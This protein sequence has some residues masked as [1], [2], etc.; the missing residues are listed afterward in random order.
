MV[1]G[2]I[3][4]RNKEGR[5]TCQRQLRHRTGTAT[6]DNHIGRSIGIVHTVDKCTLPDVGRRVHFEK[7]LHL[8]L[9]DAARLPNNLHGSLTSE[10]HNPRTHHIV[11]C[12]R[13]ERTSD[14]KHNRQRGI[15]AIVGQRLVTQR[16][17][18]TEH[19][20][21]RITRLDYLVGLEEA[22][23]TVVCNADALRLAAHNLIDQTC[24]GVL[25]LNNGRNAHTL[26]NPQYRRTCIATKANH[27]IGLKLL[28]DATRTTQA[29]EQEYRQREIFERHTTLKAHNRQTLDFVAGLWHC[30]HLHLADRADKEYLDIVAKSRSECIGNSNRRIYV[31]TGTSTGENY[32]FHKN[33]PFVQCCVLNCSFTQNSALCTQHSLNR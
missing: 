26:C 16:S 7:G 21:K 17:L 4:R 31:T 6:R 13:T 9:V 27:N 10:G 19:R 1:L 20:T 11:E 22:L 2:N 8:G 24:I 12:A 25:L 29:A 30:R 14:N 23:H 18:G 5:L 28:D 3:W 32:S 33:P 15:E